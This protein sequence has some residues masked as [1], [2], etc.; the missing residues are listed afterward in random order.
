V[1]V[2]SATPNKVF[3]RLKTSIRQEGYTLTEVTPVDGVIKARAKMTSGALAEPL[4][5]GVTEEGSNVRVTFNLSALAGQYAPEDGV[6]KE[7]CL[8]AKDAQQLAF[9]R[10]ETVKKPIE[11]R[12]VSAQ[13]PAK[14][15]TRATPS[16]ARAAES[17]GQSV[18]SP[19]VD[20]DVKSRY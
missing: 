16:P 19:A 7:F 8:L 4:I 9:T 2:K 5:V 12:S 11:R 15:K 13:A 6:H 3:E 1:T 17:R 10:Q 20:S 18:P 14:A